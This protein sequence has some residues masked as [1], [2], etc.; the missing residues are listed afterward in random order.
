MLKQV[1]IKGYKS[2]KDQ[3]LDLGKINVLIGANGIGKSNLI[4]FFRMLGAL[5]SGNL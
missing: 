2:F 5:I 4:S 1:K 3:S